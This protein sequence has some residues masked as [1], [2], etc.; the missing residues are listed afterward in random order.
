MD[1]RGNEMDARGNEQLSNTAVKRRQKDVESVRKER[2]R[3][4]NSGVQHT[5]Y[6][7]VIVPAKTPPELEVSN[8][9]L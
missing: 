7:N 2:K 5:N 9:N 8:P 4:R 6:K 3:C 1:A